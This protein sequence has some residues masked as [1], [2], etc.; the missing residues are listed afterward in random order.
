MARIVKNLEGIEVAAKKLQTG[1]VVSLPTETVYGLGADAR[2]GVAVANIFLLKGRPQFNPLI[3]HV[4]NTD[5]ADRFGEFNEGARK[6]A[7]AF[8]PGPLT[9]V[10]PRKTDCGISELVTAGLDTVA[11]RV[12]QHPIA[13]RL[14]SLAG[15]PIAAP[16]ANLSGRISPT[17]AEHVADDFKDM[18]LLV[19]DGG[20]TDL[21]LESTVVSCTDR[22]FCILRP[23]SITAE[24]IEQVTDEKVIIA[25][26]D[27]HHPVSPGQLL[28]H[29]APKSNIRL[30]AHSVSQ[31][32]GLLAFGSDI[33]D[34]A[35]KV[36]NLSESG[37]LIQAAA[38][39][40]AMLRELDAEN[41]S[42][43]AVMPIPEKGLGL[44]INDRLKRAAAPRD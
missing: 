13:Q 30:N 26:T 28:S 32:E 14:L 3:V 24:D 18:D 43:M 15:C 21:G 5:E 35:A 19:V 38:N 37:D 42:C 8:W 4:E 17:R 20:P 40:F 29:Y 6:L 2:D 44:S 39:L 33:P 34:G 27:E 25:Q 16:S 23:G 1:H 31:D 11:L 22:G 9:L 41:L 12:P 7:K 36:L 10:L